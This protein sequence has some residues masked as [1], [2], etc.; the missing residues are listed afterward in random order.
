MIRHLKEEPELLW[1]FLTSFSCSEDKDIEF[2]L[3]HRAVDFENL[4]KSRTYLICNEAELQLHSLN[5]VTIYGYISIALKILT[6]PNETSN[7]MR[8][9]LDGF[10]SK[11]HGEPIRDIPCYLIG[12]LSRNSDVPKDTLSGSDLIHYA[13]DIIAKS[14]EAVGGRFIMVECRN[15]Q[16]LLQFYQDN[17]FQEIARVP[18]MNIPMVQLLRRIQ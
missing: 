17:L 6:I 10:S 14:V 5:H 9:E 15:E 16:K 12:Q 4:S 2:F 3:H 18:D 7:R 1:Q 8:K 13:C 11:I